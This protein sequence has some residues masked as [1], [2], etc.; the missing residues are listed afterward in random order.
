MV[1]LDLLKVPHHGSQ[2]NVTRE[3][4][5]TIDCNNFL[6]STDGSRFNHPDEVA[7]ARIILSRTDT[8]HL[9]FNYQQEQT[10]LWRER[11]AADERFECH[12]PEAAGQPI[13]VDVTSLNA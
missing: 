7:I 2:N 1:P 6:I 3:L 9:H 13:V 4:L 11:A 5:E 8:V 10:D 12:F